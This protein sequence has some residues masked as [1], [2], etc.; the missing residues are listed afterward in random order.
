MPFIL[1]TNLERTAHC[2]SFLRVQIESCRWILLQ[3][4]VCHFRGLCNPPGGS[5]LRS[6]ICGISKPRY[7][8]LLGCLTLPTAHSNLYRLNQSLN[9]TARLFKL[10]FLWSFV[11]WSW[12]SRQFCV[13]LFSCAAIFI[14]LWY[15]MSSHRLRF[16]PVG[17]AN[18]LFLSA[19]L[20]EVNELNRNHWHNSTILHVAG[21]AV[22]SLGVSVR[23]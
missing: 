7:G 12:L 9:M 2:Y 16:A 18:E 6:V 19:L 21:L 11:R 8:H 14:G 1:S 22:R 15:V 17:K 13:R 10:N 5:R 20:K 4:L 23:N 3:T